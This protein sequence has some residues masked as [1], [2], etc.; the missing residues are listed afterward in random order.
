MAAQQIHWRVP[1]TIISTFLAGIAFALGHHFFYASLDGIEI[2]QAHWSQEYYRAVGTAFSF[3]VR[4][5]LATAIAAVY[6]Q[7]FWCRLAGKQL[8]V[9]VID[10]L[11][12]L[13]GAIQEFFISSAIKASPLLA[14][15]ALISWLIPLAAIF[16]PATLSVELKNATSVEAISL[17]VPAFN[18]ISYLDAFVR[19]TSLQTVC[20]PGGSCA[21]RAEYYRSPSRELVRFGRAIA[22]QGEIP[23]LKPPFTNSTYDIEFIAPTIQCAPTDNTILNQFTAAMDNCSIFSNI[24]TLQDHGYP[25]DNAQCNNLFYYVAWTMAENGSFPFEVNSTGAALL[26][27]PTLGNSPTNTGNLAA[28]LYIATRHQNQEFNLTTQSEMSDWTVTVCSL[29][30]SS[31][32]V[33]FDFSTGIQRF[34]VTSQQIL[35]SIPYIASGTDDNT[36]ITH[37]SWM[38]SS[39]MDLISSMLVGTIV[40]PNFGTPAKWD[41]TGLTAFNTTVLETSLVES[42]EIAAIVNNPY[43]TQLGHTTST[44]IS[45]ARSIEQLAA[46]ITIGLFSR[47]E[48]LT[49]D[50]ETNPVDVHI[51]ALRNVYSYNS[52]RL[53][54]SYGIACLLTL[55]IVVIGCLLIWK[56]GASYSYCFSTVVRTTHDNPYLSDTITQAA[57]NGSDPL[58]KSLAKARFKVL[59]QSAQQDG[60]PQKQYLTDVNQNDNDA[61][62]TAEQTQSGSPVTTS[63]PVDEQR[64]NDT[65]LNEMRRSSVSSIA[66]ISNDGQQ[67]NN[68]HHHRNISASSVIHSDPATHL[69]SVRA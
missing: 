43:Y 53:A 17:G 64:P 67:E 42:T 68:E 20:G 1:T 41:P 32:V 45:L 60:L 39:V 58:P 8:S 28:T 33:H 62:N 48:F 2:D 57:R 36:T 14:V 31:Q 30:N 22:Y 9:S 54:L 38:A 55:I 23:T 29:Q 66:A 10:S 18:N 16:P 7:A 44:N 21:P 51:R 26:S 47:S 59:M 24:T 13:L 46:N 52:Q 69:Q 11:A 50:N 25:D 27:P 5:A 63:A 12:N 6:W 35:N 3:L 4:A 34:S 61:Q 37:S 56:T 15:L 40:W 19:Y 65:E 49:S